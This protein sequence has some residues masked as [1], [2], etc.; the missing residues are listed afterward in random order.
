MWLCF[1]SVYCAKPEFEFQFGTRVRAAGQELYRWTEV[2]LQTSGYDC[3]SSALWLAPITR[4]FLPEA[5]RVV[6][7]KRNHFFGSGVRV[8]SRLIAYL[9]FGRLRCKRKLH[10]HWRRLES[11]SGFDH[12][13]TGKPGRIRRAN[14]HIYCRCLGKRADDVPVAKKCHRYSR[15]HVLQLHYARGGGRRFRHAIHR[16]HQQFHG[17]RYQ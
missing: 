3:S 2:L 4:S 17:R 8:S 5:L 9:G 11:H 14:R 10:R 1:S 7:A 12:Y 6:Q 15:S 16:N 13:A